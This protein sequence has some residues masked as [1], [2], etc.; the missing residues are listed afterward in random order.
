M[1]LQWDDYM[2]LAGL[3]VSWGCNIGGLLSLKHGFGRHLVFLGLKDP[4]MAMVDIQ[5][6]LKILLGFEICYWSAVMLSKL[7]M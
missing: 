3:F 2:A 6:F 1:T 4:D 7:S 5:W